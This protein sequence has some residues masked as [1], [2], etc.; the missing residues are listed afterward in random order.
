MTDKAA[1]R[2][3]LRRRR[4]A[5]A[6]AL[7][8]AAEAMVARRARPWLRRGRRVAAYWALGAELSLAPLIELARRR[9]V[10]LYLPL[11]PRRGRR[12]RFAALDDP[13]GRWR[14]NRYGIAEY[15]SPRQLP[16]NR[17]D[18]VFV[19]LV[20]FDAD[21]GR[22]GQGGGYYDTTF[23]FRAGRQ[24]WKKPRLIGVGFECQRV[25]RIPREPHDAPLDAVISETALYRP[26]PPRP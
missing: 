11:V 3:E 21:G 15:H 7:R 13:R 14:C 25:E 24:A 1:L 10:R 19:P 18:V 8:E 23:A 5:L 26:R 12:M 20:G 16:A 9:G 4:K 17:L 2:K 22:L 6:P